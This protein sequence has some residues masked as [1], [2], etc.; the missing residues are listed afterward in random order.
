MGGGG[1]RRRSFLL[2]YLLAVYLAARVRPGTCVAHGRAAERI[3]RVTVGLC[4]GTVLRGESL[5]AQARGHPRLAGAAGVMGAARM[6][7]RLGFERVSLVVVGLR[8]HRHAAGRMG[9]ANGCLCGDLGRCLKCR[10]PQRHVRSQGARIAARAGA[11]SDC[12]ALFGAGACGAARV[13]AEGGRTDSRR[14]R[15]R[16][17]LPG[18]E[19]AARQSR[20]HDGP[21]RQSHRA[22]LG[23]T[24]DRVARISV[25][26]AGR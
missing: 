25:A 15:A 16:C 8:I 10:R 11:G 2:R 14:G 7:S 17:G 13:D 1:I 5:L 21:L 12:R 20:C 22:R 19:V 3:G 6:A 18:S 9:A 24:A 23:R 26:G 4:R